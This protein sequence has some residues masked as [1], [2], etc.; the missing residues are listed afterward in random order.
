MVYRP[1]EL[2]VHVVPERIRRGLNPQ[3][4]GIRRCG[5]W[6]VMGSQGWGPQDGVRVYPRDPR[7]L[8][9]SPPRENTVRTRLPVNRGAHPHHT[10]N[11]LGSPP[12]TLSLW[13][14]QK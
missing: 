7:E 13:N 6:E 10:L 2:S 11:P 5:L 9:P 12:W 3:C 4:D 1:C 8:P 14:G